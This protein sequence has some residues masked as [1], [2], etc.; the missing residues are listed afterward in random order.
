VAAFAAA[1]SFFRL[2]GKYGRSVSNDIGSET[3]L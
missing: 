1:A 2:V 3:S